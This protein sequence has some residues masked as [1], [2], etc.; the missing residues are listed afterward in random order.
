[1]H[2]GAP[3]DTSFVYI[4]VFYVFVCESSLSSC[5]NKLCA[6]HTALY[7]QL[8]VHTA[9][10]FGGAF[11]G[12]LVLQKSSVSSEERKAKDAARKKIIMSALE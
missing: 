6:R 3:D 11:V 8:T 5:S 2:T 10:F 9:I 7:A 4:C 12:Y 1:M